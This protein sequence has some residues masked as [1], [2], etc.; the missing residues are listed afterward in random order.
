MGSLG[1][2]RHADS[3]WMLTSTPT[4]LSPAIS[5]NSAHSWG[6]SAC[7]R[8]TRMADAATGDW[9]HPI[10][11]LFFFQYRFLYSGSEIRSRFGDRRGD[12]CRGKCRNLT[13]SMSDAWWFL[14]FDP[15][16]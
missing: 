11:V 10:I 13:E 9:W 6:S 2:R 1:R 8:A 4:V 14:E 12:H 16:K 7:R 3:R 15:V 5:R